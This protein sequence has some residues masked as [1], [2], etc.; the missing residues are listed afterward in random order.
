VSTWTLQKEAI[1]IAIRDVTGLADSDVYWQ[2]TV[3]ESTWHASGAPQAQA[4][5]T[6]TADRETG[7]GE[8]RQT[9]DAD[10]D[11]RTAEVCG[12][13]VMTVSVRIESETAEGADEAAALA[14][15][16]RLRIR[17]QD[18]LAGLLAE[19]VS[20]AKVDRAIPASYPS[21]G[22]MVSANVVDLILHVAESETDTPSGTGWIERAQG[23][24][25]VPAGTPAGTFDTDI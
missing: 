6:I 22:R 13:R 20:V 9:Y 2:G 16:V 19:S 7:E 15:R 4:C 12:S 18:I 14:R 5:L 3:Q 17:T 21:Q 1:R 10:S 8:V 11:S 23:T 24:L 25:E